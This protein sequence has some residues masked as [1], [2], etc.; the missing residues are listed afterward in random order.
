MVWPRSLSSSECVQIKAET[1]VSL[2]LGQPR[3]LGGV[4]GHAP[5]SAW[6]E[7]DGADLRPIRRHRA[8]VLLIEEAVHEHA[9]PAAQGGLIVCLR[10]G[11]AGEEEHLARSRAQAQQ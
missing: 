1:I 11:V 9:Q 4:R 8:L 6:R 3:G 2:Q 5:V 7:A 10:E